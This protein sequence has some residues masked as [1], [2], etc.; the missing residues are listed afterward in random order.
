MSSSERVSENKLVHGWASAPRVRVRQAQAKDIT[1]VAALAALAQ[2]TLEAP[3]RDAMQT[4]TAGAGLR[5]GLRSGGH[6]GYRRF[7]SIRFSEET[8]FPMRPYM[9][10]ALVLVAEHRDDGLVGALIA[11]P[12]VN[13]AENV[14]AA[15]REQGSGEE[16]QSRIL[17][18]IGMFLTR[19]K[20]VAVAE[21]S[22]S[23]TIGGSL[24]K[25]CRQVYAQCGYRRT[26]GAMPSTPGLEEFYRK[27]AFDV[28]D[29]GRPLDLTTMLGTP[30]FVTPDA[31]ERIFTRDLT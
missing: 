30:T 26:Y 23:R 18:S 13:V 19:V 1:D 27:A 9:D 20:A 14:V 24:L 25:R 7:M 12:P 21:P 2:V 4:G 6:A 29:H 31:G 8:L 10:A 22:R 16:E 15:M 11:Y 28:Y 5:A 17:L 3:V